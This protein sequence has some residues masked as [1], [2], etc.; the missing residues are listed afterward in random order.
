MGKDEHI[1]EC[2]TQKPI[3]KRYE[4]MCDKVHQLDS[5]LQR[6]MSVMRLVT[7]GLIHYNEG[8]VVASVDSEL[9]RLKSIYG[10][11]IKEQKK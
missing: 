5:D 3:E 4:E 2:D 1:P 11:Y 10:P 9:L 8:G 6:A 7:H